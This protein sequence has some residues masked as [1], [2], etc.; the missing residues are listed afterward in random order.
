MWDIS[1]VLL[2]KPQGWICYSDCWA[3]G[4]EP[5]RGSLEHEPAFWKPLKVSLGP[6]DLLPVVHVFPFIFCWLSSTPPSSDCPYLGGHCRQERCTSPGLLVSWT[7]AWKLASWWLRMRGLCW[8]HCYL[9][10]LGCL[11]FIAPI[12]QFANDIFKSSVGSK[13][14]STEFSFPFPFFLNIEG[15]ILLFCFCFEIF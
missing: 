12:L 2:Q 6:P 13:I 4:V 10:P 7:C 3:E 5:T 8:G 11:I 14:V 15:L 1:N 9:L